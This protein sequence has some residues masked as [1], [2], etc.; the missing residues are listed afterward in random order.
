[1]WTIFKYAIYI[2]IVVG[3][4]YFLHG[5]FSDDAKTGETLQ[6]SAQKITVSAQQM[7]HEAYD[8]LMQKT[9]AE[10]NQLDNELKETISQVEN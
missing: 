9:N 8:N 4:F 7:M 1:M 3:L 10:T 5:L 2:F 6:S